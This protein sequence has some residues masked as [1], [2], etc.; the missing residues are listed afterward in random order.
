MTNPKDLIN[1]SLMKDLEDD[2]QWI[3]AGVIPEV[4]D[5]KKI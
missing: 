3:W 1:C 5:R 2:E 4:T